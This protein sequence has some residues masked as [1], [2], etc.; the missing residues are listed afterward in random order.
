[1]HPASKGEAF[2]EYLDTFLNKTKSANKPTYIVGHLNLNLLDH[3]V[4]VKY[5]VTTNMTGPP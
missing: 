4:N 5:Q 2:E 1:M 3:D